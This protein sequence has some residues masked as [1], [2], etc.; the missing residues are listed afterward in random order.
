[1]TRKRVLLAHAGGTIGMRRGESGYEPAPGHLADLLSSMPQLASPELPATELY[2]FEP[3]L[4]SA[5]MSPSDWMA[6]AKLIEQRYGEFDGFVVLHGTDT[7]AYTSSALSFLLEGLSKPVVVT[8]S[9]LPLGVLRTDATE[10]LLGALLLASA[11]DLHEVVVC[12]GGAVMRG[13]RATK[14]SS[15]GFDAFESPN[16]PRIAS[17][18]VSLEP[19]PA[20]RLPPGTGPLRVA[21]LAEVSVAALRLFPGIRTSLVENVLRAPLAGLVLETFGS[22]NAPSRDA[23]LLDALASAGERGVV[24]VNTTQCLRGGVDMRGYATGSALAEA[25]VVSGGDMTQEAALA[26]LIWLLGQ[27]LSPQ[28]V[29]ALVQANLRGELTDAA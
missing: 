29:R 15:T 4:D 19:G 10:N 18:G 14:V 7:L 16:E 5:D 17:L 23:T 12:F 27:G 20:I 9:Q 11:D 6:I 22:G 25:G 24:I 8:G 26:K 28:R 2:E 3:L 1:M 21:R 13:N